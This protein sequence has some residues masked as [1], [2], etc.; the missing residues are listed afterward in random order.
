[1]NDETYTHAMIILFLVRAARRPC[2]AAVTLALRNFTLQIA[3]WIRPDKGAMI[4]IMGHIFLLFVLSAFGAA[5]KYDNC[6]TGIKEW[7]GNLKCNHINNNEECAYD[8]GDCCPCT[9]YGSL[10]DDLVDERWDMLCRDPRSGCLDPRVDMY[11]RCTDGVIPDIGDGWCDMVNNNKG[12]LF[13]GGDCCDC[14]RASNGSSFSLCADPDAACYNPTAATVQSSCINGVMEFIGDGV[15]DAFNNNKGCLY[16]GGDCCM[17]SCTD[18]ESWRCGY[19]GFPCVD[20]DVIT[21]EANLCMELAFPIPACPVEFQ[22]EWVVESTIQARALVKAARCSGGSFHVTWKGKVILDE[23]IS[24]FNGTSLNVTSADAD[25]AIVGDGKS[26][27]FA[28]VNA[29]L[30]LCSITLSNGNTSYGGAIAASRSRVTFEGVAFTGNVATSSGG[31]IFLSSQTNASFGGEIANTTFIGNA[32]TSGNGGALYVEGG[33][34]VFWT[35]NSIFSE[36]SCLG[37]GGAVSLVGESYA[38]W[39]GNTTFTR[40]TATVYGGAL[41]LAAGSSAVWTASA[42]FLGNRASFGGYIH[43]FLF[44]GHLDGGFT[45]RCQQS[46]IWGGASI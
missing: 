41:R 39:I 11:P 7:M 29:S 43:E 30:H 42:H 31:A 18:G 27:L 15:C 14:T 40:N 1:M 35:G 21:Q 23:T 3:F 9:N 28:I 25:S 12:C 6:T 45:F 10:S 8:G 26:R 34:Y 32:A 36:N 38:L 24:I 5:G 33:S 19:A 22:S 44:H 17:C 2:D 20:P 16:D 37:D 46:E 13:D 4:R